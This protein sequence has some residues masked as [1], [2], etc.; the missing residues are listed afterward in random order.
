M[1]FSLERLVNQ[2]VPPAFTAFKDTSI[3][4]EIPAIIKTR[5]Q[6]HQTIPETFEDRTGL[7]CQTNLSGCTTFTSSV[8][9]WCS[10][11]LVPAFKFNLLPALMGSYLLFN[12]NCGKE[13]GNMFIWCQQ[14]T[15]TTNYKWDLEHSA[16][17]QDMIICRLHAWMMQVHVMHREKISLR[18]HFKIND[19]AFTNR[20]HLTA[21]LQ[22][23]NTNCT[24]QK[25]RNFYVS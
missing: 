13:L 7:F 18:I 3:Y 9:M 16:L 24:I 10:L 25:A 2:I 12:W 17:H 20:H 6:P 15:H 14:H 21:V 23:I 4:K 11:F 1:H 19:Y 5:S 8:L 22:N